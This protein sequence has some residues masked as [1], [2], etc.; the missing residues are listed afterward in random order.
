N[1]TSTRTIAGHKSTAWKTKTVFNS[2]QT[3][4]ELQFKAPGKGALR[5]IN[6]IVVKG[7][8]ISGDMLEIDY[9]KRKITLNGNDISN[10]LVIMQSNYKELDIGTVDFS[11]NHKTEIYYHERY[12]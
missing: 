11:A 1:N 8:F 5:D 4:Y 2:K 12:Y 9:S 6:K 3:G 7:N 10:Q